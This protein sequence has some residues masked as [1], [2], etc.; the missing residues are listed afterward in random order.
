MLIA[1]ATLIAI[2]FF[3]SP[4]QI[5]L[6]E[7]IE[8][9]IKKEVADKSLRKEINND[10]ASYESRVKN[11]K[12]IRKIQRK[13]LYALFASKG[14]KSEDFEAHFKLMESTLERLQLKAIE[15]RN[16]VLDKITKEEWAN[17]IALEKE[18]LLKA[19]EKAAKKK[20]KDKTGKPF[21]KFESA[22]NSLVIEEN[23]REDAIE[24]LGLLRNH[25]A[26]LK[27]YVQD[28]RNEYHEVITKKNASREDLL[29]IV[30]KNSDL[31]KSSYYA[32]VDIYKDL[33]EKISDDNWSKMSK[34]FKNL[35]Y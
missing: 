30:D 13:E 18:R 4:E 28:T 1:T 33:S 35:I 22:I 34:E 31:R 2:L 23:E 29:S 5:F 27:D 20:N 8:K 9:G 21:A 16:V 6:I 24:Q 10:I 19:E 12:K 7:S 17:I 15:T 14:S 3:G 32:L 11:Y 26:D 25:Y